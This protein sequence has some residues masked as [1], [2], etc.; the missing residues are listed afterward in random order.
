MSNIYELY[1]N[2]ALITPSKIAL[3]IGD[4]HVSYLEMLASVELLS[5]VLSNHG[6][7]KGKHIGV[8]LPNCREFV[9]LMLAA[10]KLGAVLVPLTP[11][12]NKIAVLKA[13]QAADVDHL[14]SNERILA[15]LEITET[16]LVQGNTF[17]ID[18]P[19]KGSLCLKELM[20]NHNRQFA[21][22]VNVSSN[23]PFILTMTSGS[24][25]APK[26]I[27]LTQE[28]K[29]QRAKAAQLAYDIS[30]D[31]VTLAA[32]PLYHSL[33]ERLVV[34]PLIT[35]GTSVVLKRFTPK[36]W[37]ETISEMGVTFTIAVSS[38]LAQVANYLSTEGFDGS[39]KLRCLV[40]SSALLEVPVKEALLRA[41][42][43]EFHECYG[44]SEIAIATSIYYNANEGKLDSV[45]RAIP[46]VDL[47]I[48]DD[49]GAYV[50]TG[51]P[52]EIV[53][54]TPM[55]Y[56]GYYKLPELTKQAFIEGYFRTGDIGKLDSDGFLK[57]LGRKKEIIISGGIN[58][59][60]SDIETEIRNIDS[61]KECAA[62]PYPDEQLGEVIAVAIVPES[63][64]D[65]NL[66]A[67]KKACLIALSDFQ[68]PR[69]YFLV[70][71]LPKN[72]LGKLMKHEL[73]KQLI[74][75][76]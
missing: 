45:G 33:A 68:Q 46:G 15:Q 24:T 11:Y 53:C 66:R 75:I 9:E 50:E 67:V 65:F 58:I 32:T 69:K 70:E 74:R 14:V 49:S 1:K 72:G 51:Q 3:V 43:C 73:I 34:T 62:F 35:G 27:I 4:E 26:P 16:P 22:T 76:H 30:K 7:I 10:A 5:A 56:G 23:E 64:E 6:V 52:G 57:F 38:Q 8:L 28:T 31:D 13:F 12:S 61:V 29:I 18:E 21:S 55:I 2:N 25:G 17:S 19:I 39:L 40:S 44:T 42:V 59:Y 71:E 20:K 47:K 48:V 41:L 63:K 36:L 60:P 54:K 37:L